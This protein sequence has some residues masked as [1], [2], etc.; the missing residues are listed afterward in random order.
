MIDVPVGNHFTAIAAGEIHNLSL[1][2]IGP[3]PDL[4]I[5]TVMGVTPSTVEPENRATPS[6]FQLGR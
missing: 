5:T 2:L 4:V 6:R 1:R 3:T